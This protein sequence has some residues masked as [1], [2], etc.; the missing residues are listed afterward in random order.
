[1]K[2]RLTLLF[3]LLIFSAWG[4]T[5]LH[6]ID[7]IPGEH[8]IGYRHFVA[9]D[10]TRSYQRVNDWTNETGP[11]PILVSMWYPAPETTGTP[12]LV[13]DY[14]RI[15]ADEEEWEH[16]PDEHFL[17]WFYY[18][19]TPANQ[20]HLLERAQAVLGAEQLTG[21]YPVVV[22]APSFRASSIENFAL[23]EMLA[24]HGY[25]VLSSPSRGT[26]TKLFEGGTVKDAT[27][28]AHDIQFLLSKVKAY[29]GQQ[30]PRIATMGF[31]F[32]G[33]AQVLAQSQ[34]Q[35]IEAMVSLDGSIQ[36]QYYKAEASPFFNVQA[37]DIPF[38]H[39][40][41]K[42]IPMEVMLA[43]GL[44]TTLNHQFSFYDQ[45]TQ[46]QAYHF[47]CLD[48]SHSYFSTLGVLFQ[49]RDA[50]QDRPDAAIMA[51]YRT[52]CEYS[53]QF[54]EAYLKEDAKAQAWLT[55]PQ[56]RV[57]LVG[58]KGPADRRLGLR[59]FHE[60]AAAQQYQGLDLLF[61]EMQNL[62]S[63]FVLPEGGLNSLGLQLTFRPQSTEG[64]LRVLE[65]ATRL[66]PSS[67]NLFDSLAEAYLF[68]GK[69]SQAL[70][71]F[72]KSLA[73]DSGNTNAVQRIRE[74][75]E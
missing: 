6:A 46:A 10:S 24:S 41:Q 2:T 75:T 21:E 53:L 73:L 35:A 60:R 74:L 8:A 11:R 44:D 62:Q 58:Q 69:R 17:N 23:C 39:L 32:G 30:A 51:S 18:P 64:G 9:Y 36:Y 50:R 14:F 28:Q 49:T 3:A 42:E 71:A 65:F 63:G 37:F 56:P 20:A 59:E 57:V 15:L 72:R 45:L 52:V 26:L 43:D 22:Y 38:L 67:A 16:L 34:N 1:M 5:S 66:H 61:E 13:N 31:S 48:L 4:Q 54:L 47:Q 68:A 55:R 70:G 19:N 33:L 7:L 40:S 25:I 27:T 12:M 29:T